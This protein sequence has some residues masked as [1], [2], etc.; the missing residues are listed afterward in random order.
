[1][2]KNSSTKS[3]ILITEHQC[4]ITTTAITT[5]TTTT[6]GCL[7]NKLSLSSVVG[8][9]S[10]SSMLKSSNQPD[11]SSTS[12]TSSRE[13]T[14][15]RTSMNASPDL[16]HVPIRDKY[17]GI[18]S[19]NDASSYGPWIIKHFCS[20]EEDAN[21]LPSSSYHEAPQGSSSELSDDV[22]SCREN[23]LVLDDSSSNIEISHDHH[24][25]SH[26]HTQASHDIHMSNE[27]SEASH[28]AHVSHSSKHDKQK[29]ASL[30]VYVLNP[31]LKKGRITN[32]VEYCTHP[33]T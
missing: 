26:D 27:H 15:P 9:Q 17:N 12:S 30:V 10:A 3:P 22:G 29:V 32:K 2:T 33:I 21:P 4:T 5:T 18:S 13:V 16:E 24:E 31:Y 8:F 23:P 19:V 14:I 11:T 6:H 25:A 28:D 1:M 7:S 20:N